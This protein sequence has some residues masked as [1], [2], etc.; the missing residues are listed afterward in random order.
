VPTP[1]AE[2]A[3]S[4]RRL[5]RLHAECPERYRPTQAVLFSGIERVRE[6]VVDLTKRGQDLEAVAVVADFERQAG[7]LISTKLAH[8]P[9]GQ[10]P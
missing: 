9:L 4:V 3:G 6:D 2:L 8:A 7:L 5:H 10:E 1:L